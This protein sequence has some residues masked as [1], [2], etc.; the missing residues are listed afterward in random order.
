MRVFSLFLSLLFL[1]SCSEGLSIFT[2]GGVILL[3]SSARTK[4]KEESH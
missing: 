2:C 4:D 3:F 1:H